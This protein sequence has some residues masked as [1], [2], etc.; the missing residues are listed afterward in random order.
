MKIGIIGRSSL[1]MNTIMNVVSEGFEISF[2]ITS[3]EAP[4][5]SV[6]SADFELMAESL[7]CPFLYLPSFKNE[8]GKNFID[9]CAKTDICLSVNY[10][11]VI[12]SEITDLFP[13][14]ILNAHLGDLPRYRG[15]ATGAWAIING[16]EK[17]GLCIHKMVG[18]ELDSGDIVC[19]SYHDNDGDLRVGQ[20][21]DW[22]DIE[23]PAQFVQAINLLQDSSYVLEVQDKDPELSLRTFPRQPIDGKI[24]FEACA[25]TIHRLVNAS[26]EPFAGAFAFLKDKKIVIW[27]SSLVSIESKIQY[28]PGQIVE[29]NE[30]TGSITVGCAGNTFLSLHDMEIDGVRDKP[31]RFI[32]SVRS[33]LS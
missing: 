23:I 2:I 1:M 14:G 20:L 6:S 5:Y 24:N 26:S 4:E 17:V 10:S 19:K 33:R 12:P 25:L 3:K 16:E 8:I 11:G 28:I 27:R 32:K 29:Y 15:N 21:Y 18:G 13:L 7:N 30:M 9:G 22:M 31:T